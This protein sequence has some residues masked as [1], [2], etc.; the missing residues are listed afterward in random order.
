M[1]STKEEREARAARNRA[2]RKAMADAGF[3]RKEI[4]VP[5][6]DE[7]HWEKTKQRLY[8]RWEPPTLQGRS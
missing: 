1:P 7:E 3:S 5:G 6:D 2:Y 4:W 8:K